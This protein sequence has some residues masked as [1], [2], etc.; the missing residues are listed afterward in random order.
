M[1]E[2]ESEDEAYEDLINTKIEVVSDLSRG[3]IDAE[4]VHELLVCIE[5]FALF[6]ENREVI[7]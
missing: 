5:T 2:I 3:I 4:Q 1:D 7:H 6:Y